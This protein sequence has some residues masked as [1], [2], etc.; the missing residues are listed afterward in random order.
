M[1]ADPQDHT[2]RTERDQHHRGDQPGLD[3]HTFDTG[4]AGGGNRGIKGLSGPRLVAISLHGADF[5]HR[6]VH[7]RRHFGDTVLVAARQPPHVTTQ[8]QNGNQRRRHTEDDQQRQPRAGGE[9]QHQR[10]DH[11]QAVAQQHRQ[12]EADDLAQLL[13]V[14]GHARHD[15]A[16]ARGVEEC[17]RQ[18]QHMGKHRTPQV[19]NHLFTRAHHQIKTGIGRNS[20]HHRNRNHAGQRGIEHRRI[21]AAETG[22]DDKTQALAQ[23]QHRTG[24]HQQRHQCHRD[25]RAIRQQEAQQSPQLRDIAFRCNGFS[26]VQESLRSQPRHTHAH[27]EMRGF[28]R[29]LH[30]LD[31]A[32]FDFVFAFGRNGD[33]Q[34]RLHQRRWRTG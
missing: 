9:Q 33:Q 28:Q 3:A 27:P 20:E 8:Q 29:D 13:A 23:R 19:G 7:L 21:A 24:C 14:V 22:I 25:A 16:G 17:R 11:H 26:S 1:T 34:H 5:M 31:D 6:L 4:R 18:C 2:D 30:R 32:D 10:A 12:A 15:V